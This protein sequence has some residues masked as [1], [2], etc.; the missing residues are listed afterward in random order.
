MKRAFL[1]EKPP[2]IG[3]SHSAAEPRDQT[4]QVEELKGHSGID[5]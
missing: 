1:P 2:N 5:R 3:Q 4:I